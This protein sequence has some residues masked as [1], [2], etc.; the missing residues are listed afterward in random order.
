MIKRKNWLAIV[1]I[2]LFSTGFAHAQL[3]PVKPDWDK[4][5]GKS[6]NAI[7]TAVPMLLIA[8]DS[9]AGAM[10]DIGVATS[11]DANSTHWNNAK[12]AFIPNDF[13]VSLSYS[14]WMLSLGADMNLVYLSGYKR[15]NKQSTLAISMLY[16]D[17]GTF[18]FTDEQGEG[19]GDYKP[20][21][22]GIDATYSMK[23]S[24]RLS[25]AV[26]GRFI[27]SDLTAGQSINGTEFH[28]ANAGSAD[29]GL[30]WQDKVNKEKRLSDEY[31]VGLSITNLGT[32]VSYSDSEDDKEFLPANLRLG[33]RYTFRF[34]EY[35]DLSLMADFN[36]LLVPTPPVY[37][38]AGNIIAGKDPNVSVIQGVFQSFYDAPNGFKEEMQEINFSVGAEYWYDQKFAAR[39]GYYY[40]SPNKGDQQYLTIG[41]GLRYSYFGLDIS[42]LIPFT[43]NNPLK[44][45]LRFTLMVDFGKPKNS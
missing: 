10:G 43:A 29:I 22:M 42:Y 24:E 36:K 13:G 31:A 8:P 41:G 5:A 3:N 7:P 12:Y 11:P 16:F 26:S 23:L 30:Y 1:L 21:E 38:T 37:D 32:K 40:Q 33:G 19:Q 4:A 27:R 35:N 39:I 34:D 44:N 9:R 45:T 25:A 17:L 20:Y 18:T 6:Y 28:A 14:P 15:I 2:T